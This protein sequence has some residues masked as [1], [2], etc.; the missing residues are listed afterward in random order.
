[1]KH[2]FF[3]ILI[4]Y[5]LLTQ[6]KS[7][8]G[9][10]DDHGGRDDDFPDM[11]ELLEELEEDIKDLNK[12]L[13]KY[14]TL[15]YILIP[16]VCILFLIFI[17]ILI[18]ELVKRCNKGGNEKKI[19]ETTGYTK[20]FDPDNY[21]QLK[22]STADTLSPKG[23]DTGK[24]Q[25]S[26][27]SSNMTKSYGSKNLDNLDNDIQNEKPKFE[28]SNNINNIKDI[29]MSGAVAP[30][31]QETLP[32]SNKNERFLTNNGNDDDNNNI[33]NMTNPFK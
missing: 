3:I 13:A 7:K 15:I 29:S 22:E 9:D 32:Y 21:S 20:T 28:E 11:M 1:M 2:Y 5:L 30:V 26:L 8:Y 31:I 33:S 27:Q 16:T 10:D 25:N 23:T 12:D 18:F 19:I 17:F 24:V 4:Q 6:V 14:D